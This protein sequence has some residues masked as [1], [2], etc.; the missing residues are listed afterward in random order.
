[1]ID[2]EFSIKANH[3]DNNCHTE[4]DVKDE[5]EMEIKFPIHTRRM[6]SIK[7]ILRSNEDAS[8]F[9]KWVL[10]NFDIEKMAQCHWENLLTHLILNNLPDTD[11]F[12]KQRDT[13]ASYLSEIGRN[14]GGTAK[15]NLNI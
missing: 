14:K 4:K 15:A 2:T 11:K 8:S 9:M 6:A 10:V 3:F 1:M 12:K 7:P 13:I 5:V